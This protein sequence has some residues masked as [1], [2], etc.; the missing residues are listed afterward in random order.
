MNFN[1]DLAVIFGK[2]SNVWIISE[3]MKLNRVI[4]GCM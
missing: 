2:I 1:S 3:N 4:L